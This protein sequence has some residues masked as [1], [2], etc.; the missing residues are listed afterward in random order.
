MVEGY[1]WKVILWKVFCGGRFF[2][3]EGYFVVKGFFVVE[4]IR[5]VHLHNKA[6]RKITIQQVFICVLARGVVF[7]KP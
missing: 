2:V 1:L 7:S 3:V 4:S 6:S 5:F